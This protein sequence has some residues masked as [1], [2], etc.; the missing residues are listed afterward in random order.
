[1][2]IH[3]T[4]SGAFI[5]ESYEE[6]SEELPTFAV[7]PHVAE[8]FQSEDRQI[9]L[10]VPRLEFAATPEK[11]LQLVRYRVDEGAATA[12]VEGPTRRVVRSGDGAPTVPFS[13]AT[14]EVR[15]LS[16]G[17]MIRSVTKRKVTCAVGDP[18]LYQSETG[19]DMVN[20]FRALAPA[21]ELIAL[22]GG[23]P[24]LELIALQGGTPAHGTV[25]AVATVDEVCSVL[26]RVLCA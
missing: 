1:V 24:A 23:T 2:K 10:M 19:R 18:A 9:K 7:P 25:Y 22:Q 8:A 13:E 3:K 12:F 4:A 17:F 14:V 5:V 20:L 6:R 21:L 26:G 16:G 11:M 15:A